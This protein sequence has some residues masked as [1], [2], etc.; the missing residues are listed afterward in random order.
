MYLLVILDVL[1]TLLFGGN[2][3]EQYKGRLK[4]IEMDITSRYCFVGIL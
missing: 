4:R 1:L 2:N 3:R